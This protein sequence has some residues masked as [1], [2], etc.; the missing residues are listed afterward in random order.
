MRLILARHGNTFSPKDKVVWVGQETDLPLAEAGHQ[1]AKRLGEALRDAKIVLSRIYCGPLQRTLRYAEI[2]GQEMPVSAEPIVDQRL[3]EIDYGTWEGLSS[4]EIIERFGLE[5]IAA[6][7]QH[8]IWPTS[9]A[10]RPSEASLLRRIEEFTQYLIRAHGEDDTVLAISSNGVLRFFL[11]LIAGAFE[12]HV[13]AGRV[14]VAT[15]NVCII[16]I[17]HGRL[18]LDAWNVAP[19]C[20]TFMRTGLD[21]TQKEQLRAE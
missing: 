10:W 5:D 17:R 6:W 3:V 7:E 15:G 13:R 12:Q 21:Y 14:K 19:H 2:V 18:H 9:P 8:S 16:D 20:T 4:A 1:Q 11:R